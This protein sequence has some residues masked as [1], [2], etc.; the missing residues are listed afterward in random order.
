MKSLNLIA[1]NIYI[2]YNGYFKL[3]HLLFKNIF[4]GS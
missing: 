1:K 4:I 3:L 2:L